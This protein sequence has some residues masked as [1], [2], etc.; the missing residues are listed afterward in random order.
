M[1]RNITRA[2]LAIIAI[3]VSACA[4][5]RLDGFKWPNSPLTV[6]EAKPLIEA[7]LCKT[8]AE[9]LEQSGCEEWKTFL[10]AGEPSLPPKTFA[11]GPVFRVELTK[12]YQVLWSEKNPIYV[13]YNSGDADNLKSIRM[14]QVNSDNETEE[15]EAENYLLS[16]FK[17]SRDKQSPFHAYIVGDV[18]RPHR[19]F[20]FTSR[21]DN[22]FMMNAGQK[23]V[24][25]LRQEGKKIYLFIS[26]I[27]SNAY[28]YDQHPVLYLAV[29]AAPE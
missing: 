19:M 4:T 7:G 23:D 22:G 1:N 20:S 26:S 24:A 2:L 29:L 14:I 18:V 9:Y 28:E 21:G 27:H 16:A 3:S 17:G 25:Y 5:T 15:R 8:S 11:V 12:S 13:L 6:E 10:A